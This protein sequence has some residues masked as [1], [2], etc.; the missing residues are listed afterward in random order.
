M[1]HP[2]SNQLPPVFG[3]AFIVVGG[4]PM[5]VATNVL[6]DTSNRPT[7]APMWVLFLC[8]LVFVVSGMM[9]LLQG[10]SSK[11]SGLNHLFAAILLGIFCICGMWVAFFSPAEGMAGGLPF[12]SRAVNVA[13]ARMVF[14]S[15]ALLTFGMFTYALRQFFQLMK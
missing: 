15:G 6:P 5:A 9:L 8:G 4:Y 2:S 7:D 3:W 14:G 11:E 10:K 13:L 1:A 12:V